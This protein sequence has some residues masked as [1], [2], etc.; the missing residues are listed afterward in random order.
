MGYQYKCDVSLSRDLAAFAEFSSNFKL[1]E[2]G[3]IML[4]C[5][6]YLILNIL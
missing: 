3:Y 6:L 4:D 5:M 1:D 2:W